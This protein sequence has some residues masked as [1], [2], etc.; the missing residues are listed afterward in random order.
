[1]YIHGVVAQ[2]RERKKIHVQILPLQL[3]IPGSF[4]VLPES[5]SLRLHCIDNAN[6]F[7]CWPTVGEDIHINSNTRLYT[8]ALCT[9]F[10]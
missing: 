10:T 8:A 4:E 2:V 6:A 1:M 3:Y 7:Y 5:P 9:T